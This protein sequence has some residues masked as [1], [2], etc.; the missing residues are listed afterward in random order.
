MDPNMQNMMSSYL[1]I[2]KLVDDEESDFVGD[3]EEEE[4]NVERE[5][6]VEVK[7]VESQLK[8]KKLSLGE[9]SKKSTGGGGAVTAPPCCLA[10]N[11]G[12]DLRGCKKYHQ[13]HRVCEV[14]AKAPVVLVDG[15]RQRFCQQCSRFHELAEFDQTKRSCR[16]RLAGH[17]ERRRKS[18]LE[19]QKDGSSRRLDENQCRQLNE[20]TE[21]GSP[22]NQDFHIH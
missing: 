12:A 22:G 8:K 6:D 4:E 16:R 5:R 7:F 19:S 14:H 1:K 20:R 11:C 9:G 13:R 2:K 17:N 18:S 15:L 21:I 3:D 10:E